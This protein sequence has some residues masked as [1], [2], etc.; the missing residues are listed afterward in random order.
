MKT[1]SEFIADA[2]KP[3][4]QKLPGSGSTPM[5]KARNK[6]KTNSK[7]TPEKLETVRTSAKRFAEPINNPNHPDYEFKKNGDKI[8]ISSKKHPIQV[9]Y[10]SIGPNHFVQNSKLTG[11][12]K[13]RRSTEMEMQRIKSLIASNAK[14]GTI[15]SSSPVGTRRGSLNSRIGMGQV[16]KRGYQ[17]GT[18]RHLSPKQKQKNVSPLRPTTHHGNIS[19]PNH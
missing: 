4:M 6:S 3:P 10:T 12:T 15:I 14:P 7:I 16:D 8:E 9:S 5:Q 19:D 2:W 13:N 17:H 11:K 1:Y 18:A